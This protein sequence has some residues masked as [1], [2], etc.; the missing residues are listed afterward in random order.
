MATR[1]YIGVDVSKATLDWAVTTG[2]YIVLQ[3]QTANSEAG[4]KVALKLL[5]ALPD[6]IISESV[7]CMEHTGVY[8]THLLSSRTTAAFIK[9]IFPFG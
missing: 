4:I 6:F 8:C 2:K 5:K 1:F 3:T 7:C 9:F